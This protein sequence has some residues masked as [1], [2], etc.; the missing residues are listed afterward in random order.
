VVIRDNDLDLRTGGA[1]RLTACRI[2]GSVC[3]FP[4][5]A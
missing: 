5:S 3:Q 2:S 4:L 1:G